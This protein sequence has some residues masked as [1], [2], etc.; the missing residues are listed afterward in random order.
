MFISNTGI[1]YIFMPEFSKSYTC[2]NL[3]ADSRPLG[4]TH[5]DIIVKEFAYYIHNDAHKHCI[6]SEVVC[7]PAGYKTIN[8]LVRINI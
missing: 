3:T 1:T 4:K 6:F 5:A 7:F 8:I 2:I